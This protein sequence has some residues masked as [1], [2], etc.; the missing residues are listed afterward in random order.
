MQP[1]ILPLFFILLSLLT[2]GCQTTQTA[3]TTTTSTTTITLAA[4]IVLNNINIVAN[5]LGV[6]EVY[7]EVVN[8]GNDSAGNVRVYIDLMSASGEA[9]AAVEADVNGTVMILQTNSIA[10]N[11]CLAPGN[12]G[13]FSENCKCMYADIANYSYYCGYF[14]RGRVFSSHGMVTGGNYSRNSNGHFNFHCDSCNERKRDF[15]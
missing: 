8:D 11:D 14:K 10:Y 4:N 2:T 1:R 13:A 12:I 15:L 9:L 5:S 6:A 3:T 7:G